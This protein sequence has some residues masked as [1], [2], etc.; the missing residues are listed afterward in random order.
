[1][2][3]ATEAIAS[4]LDTKVSGTPIVV[5]NPLNVTREDVVE[6]NIAFPGGTPESV[7]VTDADGKKVPSQVEDGKILFVAKA[8]SMGYAVYSVLPARASNS[9]SELKVTDSSLENMRYRVKL[10]TGGDVASIY[11]KSLNKELLAAPIRLAISNLGGAVFTDFRMIGGQ[12]T[13]VNLATGADP[14]PVSDFG[15]NDHVQIGLRDDGGN[16]AT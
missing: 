7:R 1:L 2:T 3:S 5:F 16:T 11:D 10:N 4:G 12:I 13:I 15:T 14:F 6:A 9:H 8:P